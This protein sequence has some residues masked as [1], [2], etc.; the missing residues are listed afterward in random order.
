[1]NKNE[2]NNILKEYYSFS[3]VAMSKLN[4][5]D[6]QHFDLVIVSPTWK[7][8]FVFNEEYSIE[9]MKLH[10]EHGAK[11]QSKMPVGY[12]KLLYDVLKGD[13]SSFSHWDEVYYSWRFVDS[14]RNA[15]DNETLAADAFP[16]YECGS[17]GPQASK[18]LLAA[19]GNN[20]YLSPD[21]G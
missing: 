15:W 6:K 14:V 9:T 4:I 10:H 5:D 7:P 3:D 11:T 1:M 13:S 2:L 21:E 18:N 8:H 16:N 19:D 12:E 20:W 17:M